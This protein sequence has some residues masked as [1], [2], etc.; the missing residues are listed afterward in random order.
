MSKR[1]NSD[2]NGAK[3]AV[4]KLANVARKIK[5]PTLD[6]D[7]KLQQVARDILSVSDAAA[8]NQTKV[9]QRKAYVEPPMPGE[10]GA[11]WNKQWSDLELRMEQCTRTRLDQER[12][13]AAQRNC[14]ALVKSMDQ[15]VTKHA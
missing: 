7:D 4:H 2:Q 8:R 3:E 1:S 10:D 11:A 14:D 13:E 9:A 15:Y 12:L 6:L 5:A